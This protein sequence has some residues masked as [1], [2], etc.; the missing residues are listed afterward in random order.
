MHCMQ[1]YFKYVP[2]IIMTIFGDYIQKID[3]EKYKGFI[4][5]RQSI[6]LSS[7][8]SDWSQVKSF[9]VKVKSLMI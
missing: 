1:Y 8:N 4:M 6:S 3:A 9:L 2:I 7:P 5:L